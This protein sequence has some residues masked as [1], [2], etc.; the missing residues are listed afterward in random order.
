V[1][2]TR[3]ATNGRAAAGALEPEPA[4]PE[5][6]TEVVAVPAG[7]IFRLAGVASSGE[8]EALVRTALVSGGPSLLFLRKGDTLPDGWTVAEVQEAAVVL[9]DGSGGRRVLRLP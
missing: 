9:T 4:E 3:P 1:F 5:P 2:A 7:P 8:G 6:R